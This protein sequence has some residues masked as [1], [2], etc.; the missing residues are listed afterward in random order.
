VSLPF[1]TGAD[2]VV[3]NSDYYKRLKGSRIGLLSNA[4]C[5]L[6]D[7]TPILDA[8]VSRFGSQLTRL[9]APEHGWSVDV[10]AGVSVADGAESKTGLSLVS[11]YNNS[12]FRDPE[13][14]VGLDVLVI[15]LRDIG[16]RCYT[17]A[18]TAALAAEAALDC[19]VEVILCDRPNPLLCPIG[20]PSP[21]EISKDDLF[22]QFTVPFVH[23]LRISEL[24]ASRGLVA[25]DGMTVATCAPVD[26]DQSKNSVFDSF[27]HPWLPPSPALPQADCLLFYPGLVMLE[28]TNVSEGRGTEMPFRSVL[29]PWLD[30]TPLIE[31]AERNPHWGIDLVPHTARPRSGIYAGTECAGV[32]VSS[33]RE[34]SV[35]GF[36]FGVHLLS[37][38]RQNDAFEWSIYGTEYFIDRLTGSQEIRSSIDSGMEPE[39]VLALWR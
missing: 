16:V 33:I 38:L 1:Q 4:A 14:F 26:I 27:E 18:A 22:S 36:A 28:G 35:N 17:Y 34:K 23:G 10:E 29:A 6:S 19:G 20:G 12:Q 7:G 25:R 2:R 39:E 11:L 32:A 5:T 9:F 3:G 13:K 8:F 31:L 21:V 15:D 37:C 30:A 24:F